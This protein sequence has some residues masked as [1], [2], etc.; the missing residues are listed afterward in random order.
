MSSTTDDR[1]QGGSLAASISNAV[2]R[3]TADYTGRGPTKARTTIRDELVV[4]MMQ[5][6]LTKAERTLL[7]RGHGEFVLETRR[8][9]QDTMRDDLVAAV[10][11]LC[12]RKVVAFMSA[13]H[14]DPDMSAEIFVM[15]A[16]SAE[17]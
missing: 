5:D 3:I 10:E 15:E 9:F 7:A 6:T 11:M 2:V 13:N 16:A 12:Q 17:S 8:R 4:V 14:M 1:P